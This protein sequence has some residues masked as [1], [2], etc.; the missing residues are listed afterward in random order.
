MLTDVGERELSIG[1]LLVLPR[2][3]YSPPPCGGDCSVQSGGRMAVA[4]W[5]S[6]GGHIVLPW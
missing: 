2:G 3:L 4:I 5:Q 1:L 6:W